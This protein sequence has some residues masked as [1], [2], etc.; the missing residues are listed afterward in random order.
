MQALGYLAALPAAQKGIQHLA[1]DGAR[2][3][4]G[5]LYDYVVEALRPEARFWAVAAL[6]SR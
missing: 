3:D 4:D 5:D 2:P 6:I 1:N